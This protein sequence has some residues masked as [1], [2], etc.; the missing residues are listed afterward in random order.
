MHQ[1]QNLASAIPR[2]M[3]WR[4]LLGSLRAT[5][6]ACASPNPSRDKSPVKEIA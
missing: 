5:F 4:A 2:L 6:T 3:G 1:S